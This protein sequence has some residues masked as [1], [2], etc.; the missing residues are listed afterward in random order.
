MN[1]DRIQT[2]IARRHGQPPPGKTERFANGSAK[3][4]EFGKEESSQ[5]GSL[6]SSQKI[7]ELMQ[8]DPAITI[9]SLARNAGI[10]DRAIKKQI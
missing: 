10:T 7:M 4:R 2:E 3:V 1:I 5:K 6:K 8:G 9:G